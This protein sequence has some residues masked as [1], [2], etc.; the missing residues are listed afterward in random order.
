MYIHMYNYI[1]YPHGPH[2][3]I[4]KK[5]SQASEQLS[6]TLDTFW[7]EVQLRDTEIFP[8]VDIDG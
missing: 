5:I 2:V 4:A 8:A 1:L 3:S 7:E 6:I